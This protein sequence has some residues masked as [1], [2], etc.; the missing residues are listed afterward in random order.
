MSWS[1]VAAVLNEDLLKKKS[2]I[3]KLR[4]LPNIQKSE[5]CMLSCYYA[6]YVMGKK[7]SIENIISLL[8]SKDYHIRCA[9]INILR[10]FLTS[11]NRQLIKKITG[12]INEKRRYNCCKGKRVES[13]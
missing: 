4:K 5:H 6:L 11:D 13:N 2:F 3:S 1:D 9:V 8:N 12:N 10:G 7:K